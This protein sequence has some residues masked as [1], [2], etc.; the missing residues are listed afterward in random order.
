MK[1]TISALVIALGAILVYHPLRGDTDVPR[2]DV[3]GVL[4]S[5]TTCP[6]ATPAWLAARTGSAH[7]ARRWS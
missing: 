6:A 2:M 3:I 1:K 4:V 7:G 5:D